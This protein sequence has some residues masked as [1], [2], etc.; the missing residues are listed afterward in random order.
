M[1]LLKVK[2]NKDTTKVSDALIRN[3]LLSHFCMAQVKESKVSRVTIPFNVIT[4]LE[5][6]K[7][8]T[9]ESK[10]AGENYNSGYI[11]DTEYNS[12]M[13]I[14]YEPL[15]CDESLSDSVAGEQTPELDPPAQADPVPA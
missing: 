9:L 4:M 2:I 15:I 8:E 12:E 1:K 10:I 7:E 13:E 3:L 11:E 5:S 6:V 14:K